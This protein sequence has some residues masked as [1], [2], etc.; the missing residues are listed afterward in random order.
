[1]AYREL[2]GVLNQIAGTTNL[3]TAGAANIYA[4]NSGYAGPYNLELVGALNAA[5]VAR[6]LQSSSA[7]NRELNGICNLLA[8]TTGRSAVGALNVL[9]GSTP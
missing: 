4:K 5:A 8:G 7:P 6:G 2:A 1:M 3:E 9:A